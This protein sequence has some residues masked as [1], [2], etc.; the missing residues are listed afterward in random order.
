MY[1]LSASGEIRLTNNNETIF[2]VSGDRVECSTHV[3]S[4][5]IGLSACRFFFRL[6]N[7]RSEFENNNNRGGLNVCRRCPLIRIVNVSSTTHAN[8]FFVFIKHYA[9]YVYS[10]NNSNKTIKRF[11]M[12]SRVKNVSF[13]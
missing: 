9:V 11:V 2:Q 7:D 4:P 8:V 10:E 12:S 6:K 5:S 3:F 1:T 13:P